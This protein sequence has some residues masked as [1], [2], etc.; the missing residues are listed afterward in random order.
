VIVENTASRPIITALLD[1][2]RSVAVF[3]RWHP[4]LRLVTLPQL[5]VAT[6]DNIMEILA[7]SLALGLR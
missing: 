2:F 1:V 3:K 5:A 6:G 7:M 4:V